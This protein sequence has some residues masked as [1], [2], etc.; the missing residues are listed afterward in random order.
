MFDVFCLYIEIIYNKILKIEHRSL[1]LG[2][3][4]DGDRMA[5]SM[6]NI[7]FRT[8]ADTEKLCSVQLN[9]D[10]IEK[11]K[12]AIEDLYYFEFIVG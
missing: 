7:K 8:D 1:T 3:V 5:K 11:L 10:D 4:L 2:E 6:Y 12:A 9:P